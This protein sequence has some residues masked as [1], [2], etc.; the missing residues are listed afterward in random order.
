VCGI[1]TELITTEALGE[2]K[3]LFYF[4]V[5]VTVLHPTHYALRG[6]KLGQN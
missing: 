4:T 2:H 5:G 3:H 6:E 1:I